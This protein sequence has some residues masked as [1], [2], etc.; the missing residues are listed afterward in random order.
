MEIP[1]TS[2]N[3]GVV[4]SNRMSIESE[5]RVHFILGFIYCFIPF[6]QR[7]LNKK[8]AQNLDKLINIE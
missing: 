4:K 5:V 3:N 6:V 7:L 2:M 1:E 8:T